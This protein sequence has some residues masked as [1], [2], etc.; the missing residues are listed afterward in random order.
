MRRRRVVA[1]SV[2]R[3]AVALAMGNAF[4]SRHVASPSQLAGSTGALMVS[5]SERAALR[6]RRRRRDAELAHV[7]LD[8]QREPAHVVL[9][10]TVERFE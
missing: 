3:L 1:H 2:G 4:S 7:G 6:W 10:R 5:D 9:A 8:E